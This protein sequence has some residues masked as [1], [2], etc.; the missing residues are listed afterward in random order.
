M[1]TREDLD[2]I[3]TLSKLFISDEEKDRV[4]DELSRM[5]DSVSVVAQADVSDVIFADT[6]EVTPMREDIVG[7]SLST[8]DVLSNVAYSNKGYFTVKKNG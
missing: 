7:E 6:H 2:K 8:D 5:L 1:I 4:T 3:A